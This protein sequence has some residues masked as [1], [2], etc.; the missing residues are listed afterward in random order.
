[1]EH[2]QTLCREKRR[3]GKFI[4]LKFTSSDFLGLNLELCCLFGGARGHS[5]RAREWIQKKSITLSA[6][7]SEFNNL[8]SARI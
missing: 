5:E 1:M 4:T 6:F 8:L 3:D 2:G 7:D